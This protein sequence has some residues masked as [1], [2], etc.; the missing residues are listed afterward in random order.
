ML[1]R[2]K[3]ATRIF[4]GHVYTKGYGP[5]EEHNGEQAGGSLFAPPWFLLC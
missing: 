4:V 3:A 2:T 1:Y 5:F